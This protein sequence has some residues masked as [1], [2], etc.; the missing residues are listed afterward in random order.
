MDFITSLSFSSH[1]AH[2]VVMTCIFGAQLAAV[3]LISRKYAE[4][5]DGLWLLLILFGSASSLYFFLHALVV[6]DFLIFS[7]ELFDVFE[8][9]GLFVG[10]IA[11]LLGPASTLWDRERLYQRRK[12]IMGAWMAG[13]LFFVGALILWPKALQIAYACVDYATGISGLFLLSAG[14]FFFRR[15]SVSREPL[16][17]YVAGGLLILT[18]STI[19]PFFYEEWNLLWWSN[20]GLFLLGNAAIFAGCIADRR[21][22]GRQADIS[23]RLPWYRKVKFRLAVLILLLTIIPLTLLGTYGAFIAEQ[24]LRKQAA[25]DLEHL[26]RANS[27]HIGAFISLLEGTAANFSSDGLIRRLSEETGSA[28][29]E[30]DASAVILG[31]HLVKNKMPTNEYLVGINILDAQGWIVAS[32]HD[33]EIGKDESEDEYFREGLRLPYGQTLIV[34]YGHSSHFGANEPLLATARPSSVSTGTG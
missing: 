7:E 16:D 21:K 30:A 4:T 19:L 22:T 10:G 33:A 11:L 2:S 29:E 6:P 32:T 34:D 25:K 24:S 31:Q 23:E 5:R 27:A 12:I 15:F 20:H 8:H 28:T 3:Y 18:G 1:A 14:I 17:A 13:N 26:V 9:Y